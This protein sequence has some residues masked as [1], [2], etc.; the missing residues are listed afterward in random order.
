MIQIL[1]NTYSDGEHPQG[2]H[3]REVEGGDTSADTDGQGVRVGVHVLGNVVHGL[4]HLQG[5][6]ATAV[7]HNLCVRERLEKVDV[8]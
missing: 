3:G 4:T 1:I 7:L 6:D 5:G 2:D 8:C